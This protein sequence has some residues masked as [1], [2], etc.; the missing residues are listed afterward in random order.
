MRRSNARQA[1]PGRAGLAVALVLGFGW[2]MACEQSPSQAPAGTRSQGVASEPAMAATATAAPSSSTGTGAPGG[3]LLDRDDPQAVRLVSYNV[4]WNSIFEEVHPGGAAKFSRL[5]K[6]L[7]PDILCLQEIGL[8]PEERETPG[9]RTWTAVEVAERLDRVLPLRGEH[10][11]QAFQGLDCVIASRYRLRMERTHI[12]P[13]GER[14]QSVALVDLPDDRFAADFY[15][16]NNHFKCCDPER[17]DALRQRQSDAIVAWLC[18]AR[19]SGGVVDLPRG[20]PFA[21]VGDLNIVGSTE[22]LR[23]LLE[24]D[25]HEEQLY[26][27]DCQLDWDASTL[28]DAHPRHNGDGEDDYTWRDDST[29]FAPGRLDFVLYSDSVLQPVKRLVLNTIAMDPRDLER[30]GLER[31]DACE[32]D[33]GR[34]ID[35]LPLVVDFRILPLDLR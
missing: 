29:R 32:D 10:G 3:A 28:C 30:A 13:A 34:R 19:S 1:G 33:E 6:A 4:M 8:H 23:T 25:I 17:F 22:P 27:S 31:F 2:P 26:G 20:T 11:W 18:D 5:V 35:H 14:E 15:V 9:A 16:L 7:D 21:V 12:V 24:G